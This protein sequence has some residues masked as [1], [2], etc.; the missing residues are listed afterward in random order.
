MILIKT[1]GRKGEGPEKFNFVFCVHECMPCSGGHDGETHEGQPQDP[2]ENLEM[3]FSGNLRI[4][5]S[6]ILKNSV[7][8]SWVMAF[9]LKKIN[10]IT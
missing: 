2:S 4:R 3:T 7:C 5:L 1:E 6:P 9:P 10:K 8:M